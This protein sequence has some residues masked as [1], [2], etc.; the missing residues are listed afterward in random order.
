MQRNATPSLLECASYLHDHTVA[1]SQGR[2]QLPGRHEDGEVPGDDL[3][4][5]PQGLLVDGGHHLA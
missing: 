4:H 5:H 3:A 1:S 2:A